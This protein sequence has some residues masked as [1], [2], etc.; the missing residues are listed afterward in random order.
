VGGSAAETSARFFVCSERYG[1]ANPVFTAR[2]VPISD[3]AIHDPNIESES[4]YGT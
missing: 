4:A 3:S 1:V 2:R